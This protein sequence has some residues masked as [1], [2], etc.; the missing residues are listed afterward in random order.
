MAFR[1]L[2]GYDYGIG[3]GPGQEGHGGSTF[4]GVAALSLMDRLGDMSPA[5]R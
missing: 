1:Q 5:Q 2:Q 3:Q 4:C